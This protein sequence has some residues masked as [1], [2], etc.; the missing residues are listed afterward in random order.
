MLHN[1]CFILHLSLH[2]LCQEKNTCTGK[3]AKIESQNICVRASGASE[4][5]FEFFNSFTVK[6]VSFFTINVKF[7]VILSSKSGGMFV[8][9]IPPHPNKWGG[10][11][12]PPSPPGFTPV[13]QY[14][15]DL[16]KAK[17]CFNIMSVVVNIIWRKKKK[18]RN[19]LC[20]H[21]RRRW[22]GGHTAS[23]PKIVN[24]INS[25]RIRV[26]FGDRFGRDLFLFSCQ[27]ILSE[28]LIVRR[29][30]PYSNNT[31][32][33]YNFS[34]RFL[35]NWKINDS[36]ATESY[37]YKIWLFCYV[38]LLSKFEGHLRIYTKM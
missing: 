37:P 28:V 29:M 24:V 23:L 25:G 7:K 9:A 33:W 16:E 14:N 26:E 38:G 11:I 22:G 34:K 17:R 2:K 6:K 1:V 31:K 30:Y 36:Y 27:N 32:I 8:Q 10:G 15:E 18:K 5:F 3:T 12:H 13:L 20:S 19:R 4:Q 21:R 35:N